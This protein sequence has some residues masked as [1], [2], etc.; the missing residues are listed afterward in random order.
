VDLVGAL[1]WTGGLAVVAAIAIAGNVAAQAPSDGTPKCHGKTAT[2]VVP[3]GGFV[4]TATGKADVIVGTSGN[5]FIRAQGGDDLVCAGD[6]DDSIFGAGGT[7]KLYGEGGNDLLVGGAGRD[8][9][10][11]GAGRDKCQQT[12]KRKNC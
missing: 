12:R 7:D 5:D 2:L 8:T 11:G 10:S 1:R 4:T 3:P 9:L 6:G